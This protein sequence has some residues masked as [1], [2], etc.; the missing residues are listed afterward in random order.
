MTIDGEI[1]SPEKRASVSDALLLE[2]REHRAKAREEE[3]LRKRTMKNDN[4]AL[5]KEKPLFPTQ[6]SSA[7]DVAE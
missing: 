7:D 1:L 4:E 3:A 6:S 5:L 2:K